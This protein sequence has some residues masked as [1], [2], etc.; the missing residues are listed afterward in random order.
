M[1]E[2]VRHFKQHGWAVACGAHTSWRN[3]M[4]PK[5]ELK[6]DSTTLPTLVTCERCRQTVAYRYARHTL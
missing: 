6:L 5:A 1:S 4:K 2:A 3:R